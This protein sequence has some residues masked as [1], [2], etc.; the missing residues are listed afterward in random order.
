M[1]ASAYSD[2][3]T[4]VG[5]SRV[6]FR[7][8]VTRSPSAMTAATALLES[9]RRVA[10]AEVV[11]HQL[12]GEDHRRRVHLVL[13]LVL[14]CGA[15]RRLEDG[16]A[17]ADVRAGRD[18]EPAD[19]PG[20]EVADDVPVEIREDEHVELLGAL[21]EPHAE[22]VDEHLARLDVRVVRRDVA[23]DGEEEPVRELHDVRLRD[24]GDLAGG[25][26]RARTRRRSG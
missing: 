19:E 5:S 11:E 3:P 9:L 4:A 17:R 12:P 18:P 15:V 21:D 24:A 20:R 2:V 16:R 13:A 1:I 6:G 8:Y 7:S 25:R 26:S 14:R 23:E 10:L 22:R